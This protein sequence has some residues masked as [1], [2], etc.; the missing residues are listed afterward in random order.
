MF[1]ENGFSGFLS[2]PMDDFSLANC[3]LKWLPKDKVIMR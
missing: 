2:K 3:L 1:M